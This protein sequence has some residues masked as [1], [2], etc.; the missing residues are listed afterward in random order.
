MGWPGSLESSEEADI[1]TSQGPGAPVHRTTI[2]P[3]V[4][5]GDVYIR[6]LHGEAGRWY[7]EAITNP[8]VVLHV[9]G[10]ALPARAV[11]TPDP[12][13][14][15]AASAGLQRKYADSPY[16]ES[17]IRDEI[18]ETTLRLEPR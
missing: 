10:E 12:D 17:M 6:S 5:G 15:A 16:L 4:E 3:V 7:R 18:L 14:I 13:S 9:G 1:E 8:D 2:W 11:H